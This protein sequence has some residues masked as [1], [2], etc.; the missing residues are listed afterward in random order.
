VF[1]ILACLNL[2]YCNKYKKVGDYYPYLL[3]TKQSN[4]PKITQKD[5]SWS[6]IWKII[7]QWLLL[8]P[9]AEF[10]KSI[11]SPG[12]WVFSELDEPFTNI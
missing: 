3:M 11:L 10:Q 4:L 9:D 8:E 7:W 1:Q 5:R 6:E 2:T 12:S